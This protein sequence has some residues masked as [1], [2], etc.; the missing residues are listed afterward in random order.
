MIEDEEEDIELAKRQ[1]EAK[2]L[3]ETHKELATYEKDT[4][5]ILMELEREEKKANERVDILPRE[6]AKM[7]KSV[8]L[9]V[10]SY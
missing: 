2:Y 6:V 9:S 10:A 7:N 8:E 4:D 5:E 1:K 3:V